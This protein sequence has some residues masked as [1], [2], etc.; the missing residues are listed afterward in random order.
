MKKSFMLLMCFVAFHSQAQEL[1]T[2]TEPASNMPA[3]SMALRLNNRYFYHRFGSHDQFQLAPEFMIGLSKR[4]MIHT[5]TFFSDAEDRFRFNGVSLYAKYRAYSSDDVHSHF[6]IGFFGRYSQVN[7][8]IQQQAID[9]N[10]FN[11]GLEGGTVATMLH[12][13]SAV[14]ANVSLLHA[15]D[16]G[17]DKIFNADNRQR[18]AINTSL[19]V[20]RLMLPRE[21]SSFNQTNLN[22]MIE[23]LAQVNTGNGSAFVDVAPVVQLIMKSRIRLDC[24]YRFPVVQSLDRNMSK[25]WLLRVDYNF[26]NVW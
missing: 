9:F 24:S 7:V 20:G 23:M 2:Y 21:Y 5:E 19:S 22:L 15:I 18:N 17:N 26:F 25:G 6:R 14:S 16:N 12:Q 13:R 1:F 8:P 11:S 4:L 3:K 10:G